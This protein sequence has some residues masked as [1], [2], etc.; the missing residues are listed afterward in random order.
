M[1]RLHLLAPSLF[2]IFALSI[3]ILLLPPHLANLPHTQKLIAAFALS[4]CDGMC[5]HGITLGRTTLAE[6]QAILSADPALTMLGDSQ[7]CQ[8]RWKMV[9]EGVEWQGM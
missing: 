7:V 8:V 6:A 4:K 1:L 3:S 2:T 9:I 5:W